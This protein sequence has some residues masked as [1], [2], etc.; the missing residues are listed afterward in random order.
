M[1]KI[2]IL[3]LLLII[4]G[5]GS[6]QEDQKNNDIIGTYKLVS[7]FKYEDTKIF[8]Y[9]IGENATDF[10][11][12]ITPTKIIFHTPIW[13]RLA[14]EVFDYRIID[15]IIET[16]EKNYNN[17]SV[18]K[19]EIIKNPIKDTIVLYEE[20]EGDSIYNVRKEYERINEEDYIKLIG[21]TNE[22]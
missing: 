14:K 22:E 18:R 16:D 15:N 6:K 10:F 4:T 19:Y 5:C 11:L 7:A 12:M 2:L 1:K 17:V 21:E 8:S 3:V 20:Y 13:G 9:N